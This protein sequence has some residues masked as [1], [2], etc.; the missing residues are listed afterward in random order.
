MSSSLYQNRQRARINTQRP[1]DTPG[2][3]RNR[4][5]TTSL[6]SQCGDRRTRHGHPKALGIRKPEYA[7][8]LKLVR[9]LFARL[10]GSTALR[11]A[12]H[13]IRLALD[14]GPERR[15][16]RSGPGA[17]AYHA[18]R[19]LSRLQAAKVSPRRALE[20]SVAIMLYI[21]ERPAQFPKDAVMTAR[22]V[23]NAVYRL[24]PLYMYHYGTTV[25]DHRTNSLKPCAGALDVLGNRVRV[26]LAPFV[27]N[28]EATLAEEKREENE[29]RA[30]LYEKLTPTK[31][32]AS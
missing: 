25:A 27:R 30:R 29:R 1:C 10:D 9:D 28:V 16:K 7:P 19:E 31:R 24:A 32:K 3:P 8:L 23:A 20:V 26:G 12:E 15:K 13:V 2:C 17:D 14:P 6:C 11:E 5:W 18:W 22:A 21:R 4:K